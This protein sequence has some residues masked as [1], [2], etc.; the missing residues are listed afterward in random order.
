MAGVDKKL[1][2][3][4]YFTRSMADDCLWKCRKCEKDYKTKAGAGWTNLY[5][6]LQSCHDGNDFEQAYRDSTAS[7]VNR[8]DSILAK[9]ASKK[10]QD[11]FHWIEWVV[12]RHMS[13]LEVDN[14]LTRKLC[15]HSSICSKTLRKNI[16][17]V[18]DDVEE[19]I[20]NFLPDKFSV[21]FDGWSHGSEH[22]MGVTAAFTNP[23][24]KAYC[25]VLLSMEPLLA[26]GVITLTARVH[27]EHIEATLSLY[28]KDVDN[29]LC[30][31]GDNCSVNQKVATDMDLPLLGCAAHKMNLAVRSWISAQPGFPEAIKT[32]STLMKKARTAKNSARLRQLTNLK[33]IKENDTRW[34][35]TFNMLSRYLRLKEELSAVDALVDFL[36]GPPEHRIIQTCFTQLEKFNIIMLDLQSAALSF[37]EA[38]LFFDLIL[39]DH[40][41]LATHLSASAPIVQDSTFETAVIKLHS[42]LPL[43]A[44]EKR[45]VAHMLVA[46]ATNN[47]VEDNTES[48]R[49]LSYLQ[50]VRDQVKRRKLNS[51]EPV[52]SQYISL[53][54]LPG[55]SVSL[56]RLFSAA[57]LFL[58]PGRSRTSPVLFEALLFLKHNRIFWDVHA[59]GRAMGM[60]VR[61]DIL[62]EDSDVFYDECFD[63][64]DEDDE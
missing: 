59:V 55:T 32:V 27:Q 23:K 40:P 1:V 43:N 8:I 13:L 63:E 39:V 14:T 53:D 21:L 56:E 57:K 60:Q 48:R 50:K 22:Y 51:S 29:V 30:L 35:S 12:M 4:F 16:L 42:E 34:S 20:R 9:V 6:H 45:A 15:K 33:A 11:T 52:R 64:D 19:T 46:N 18:K 24:T 26:N 10:E 37:V 49:Q 31:V 36:P 2:C 5:K 25:E 17:A 41:E 7:N 54:S 28:G 44:L 62:A 58:T 3:M 38:R 47:P 61:S